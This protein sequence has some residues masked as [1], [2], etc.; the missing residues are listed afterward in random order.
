MSITKLWEGH[1]ELQTLLDLVN[2]GAKSSSERARFLTFHGGYSWNKTTKSH[3]DRC[4]RETRL[5]VCAF[6]QPSNL[7]AYSQGTKTISLM[8]C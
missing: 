3:S 2:N 5:N 6:T 4:L 1:D 8:S 7:Y